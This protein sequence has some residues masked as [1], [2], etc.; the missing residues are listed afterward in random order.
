MP[1][2]PMPRSCVVTPRGAD[3]R[4]WGNSNQIPS[5]SSCPNGPWTDLG[6]STIPSLQW[7]RAHWHLRNMTHNAMRSDASARYSPQHNEIPK[8]GRNIH[9]A[10]H[11]RSP[12][13]ILSH[14]DC[15]HTYRQLSTYKYGVP[16]SDAHRVAL[17]D[18]IFYKYFPRMRL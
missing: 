10:I 1:S 9:N 16:E 3:A 11:K 14:P 15:K 18:K 13:A 4:G 6:P 17:R 8:S 2:Q 5:S 7:P 12:E